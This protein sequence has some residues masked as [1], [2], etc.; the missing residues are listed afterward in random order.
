V[1]LVLVT[2]L[3]V[4]FAIESWPYGLRY[5][6]FTHT[7]R[8]MAIGAFVIAILIALGTS[9]RRA[10]SFAK[11]FAFHTLLFGWLAWG[12]FPYLGELP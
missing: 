3:N 9:A 7:L 5:Q 4:W 11:D 2:I 6:G 12:A 1:L 10:P 8:I